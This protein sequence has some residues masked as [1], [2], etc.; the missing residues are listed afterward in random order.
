MNNKQL[1]ESLEKH[2]RFLQEVSVNKWQKDAKNSLIGR[3]FAN[4]R[5]IELTLDPDYYPEEQ[6]NKILNK[7]LNDAQRYAYANKVANLKLNDFDTNKIPA[8][9]MKKALRSYK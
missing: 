2:N 9:I 4:S 8:R 5:N 3:E 1:I 6:R 7:R